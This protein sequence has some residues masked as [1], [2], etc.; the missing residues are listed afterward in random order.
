MEIIK[1]LI[2]RLRNTGVLLIVGIL[3]IVYIAFGVLYFQ[4]GIRQREYGEQIA[5]LN[6]VLAR[7]LANSAQLQDRYDEIYNSNNSSLVPMTDAVAIQKIVDIAEK[8]GIDVN[9]GSGKLSIPSATRSKQKVGSTTYTVI[10]LTSIRVQGSQES[11]EAFLADIDDGTTLPTMVLNRVDTSETVFTY[12]GEEATRRREF[13]AVAEAVNSMMKD[14]G[15]SAIPNPISFAGGTAVN[16]TGDDPDTIGVIEGFPDYTT[17]AFEKGYSGNS[18]PRSGYV[19]YQHDKISTENPTVF[20]TVNYFNSPETRY[21]YTCEANGTVRQFDRAKVSE[22]TEYLSSEPTT[23]ETIAT[24]NINIY[25][26]P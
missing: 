16:I 22:A 19:L 12:T 5:Q 11:I 14:N 10:S 3:L 9:D 7:P 15:L 24:V 4:Q 17:T 13:H 20:S 23:M 6:V 1:S 21:Y 25:T 26:K 18:T 8:S 2:I